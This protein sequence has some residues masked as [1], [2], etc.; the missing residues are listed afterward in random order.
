MFKL[1]IDEEESSLL[2][3]PPAPRVARTK[4]W[5]P[6]PRL[7][8]IKYNKAILKSTDV[9]YWVTRLPLSTDGNMGASTMGIVA[10]LAYAADNSAKIFSKDRL[11]RG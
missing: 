5:A 9:T 3:C 1:A 11:R 7:L 4:A 8:P 10:C 2:A 6:I